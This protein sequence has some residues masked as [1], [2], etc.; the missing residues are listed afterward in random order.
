MAVK[1]LTA[2]AAKAI[3]AGQ[4]PVAGGEVKGLWLFPDT[5][6]NG[7]GKWIFRFVSPVTGGR[8]DMGLGSFPE[9]G[10]YEAREAAREARRLIRQ[11]NDPIIVRREERQGRKLEVLK[12][13]FQKAAEARFKTLEGSFKNSKHKNQWISTLRTYAFPTIGLKKV[14][15]LTPNDFATVLEPIWLIKPETAKRVKQ[16]C[17]DVM[18]WC[19]GS[20][21]IKINPV[22]SVKALLPKP[23]KGQR[24]FP[25]MPWRDVP[26][27][28]QDIIRS[29]I[30]ATRSVLE[31]VILT[32]TRS[33]EVRGA[34]WSE[35]DLN[36]RTWTIPEERMKA[37]EKHIIPLSDRALELLERQKS[38]HSELVF[39]SVRGKVLSDM[40]LTAF[41]RR[42][43]AHSG[44]SN[45]HAVAHG[46]R[47]SFRDWASEHGYSRDV[48]ERALAHTIK[49]KT[50]SA[51]H[52]TDL[53]PQR[54]EM[55]QHWADFLSG[56]RL[57]ET[58]KIS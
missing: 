22:P 27:F 46:F 55:M 25:A 18:E 3:K 4:K 57:A 34:K 7:N 58:Q 45:R 12:M 24:H 33:G 20:G 36:Q 2:A 53:L 42:H 11:G 39:P 50:E 17:Y 6:Q 29:D 54:T 19:I 31:F 30:D 13:S 8:R 21:Y 15:T 38:L 41:L 32:A 5:K 48:A 52:R 56:K 23:P 26:K 43:S 14:D 35:I 1:S 10:L 51:Y 49:S 16:R 28:I 9:V 37:K 44:D 47:S 40:A